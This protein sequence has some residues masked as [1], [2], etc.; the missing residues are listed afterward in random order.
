MTQVREQAAATGSG[1]VRALFLGSAKK[2]AFLPF[3]SPDAE[4]KETVDEVF[5]MVSAWADDTV[6]PAAIDAAAEIPEEVIEGLGELGLLGLIVPEEFGGAGM[7]QYA[8]AR[9]MEAV[10]H[11]CASTVT[12]IGG[13]MGLAM[14]PVLLFGTDEQKQRWLPR[15][16]AAEVLGSFALTEAGAGSDAGNQMTHAVEQPDGSFKVSGTKVMITNAGFAGVFAVFA[17]LADPDAPDAPMKDQ[18]ISCFYVDAHA[19]GV[20]VAP[21]ENKM[22]LKGSST[23]EV[24]FDEVSVPAGDLIGPRG[25]GFKVALNTLNTGRHGLA[26][27]CIGQAKLA[28][29]LAFAQA[30]ERV[31]FGQSIAKFGL[32]QEML[33]GMQADIYAMEAGT[34]L[35]AGLIDRGEE[36]YLLESAACKIFATERLWTLAND[37]LQVAGGIGF[38]KEYPFERIVRD[39]RINLI[40]EGTN[41]ILRTLVAGQGLRPFLKDAA[42]ELDPSELASAADFAPGLA[43]SA[44]HALE[45]ARDLGERTRTRAAAGLRDLLRDQPAMAR[46][47]E[48]A[49]ALY[50]AFAVLSRATAELA[51]GVPDEAALLDVANLA[52]RRRLAGA[53]QALARFDDP[54][55]TLEHR[56]VERAC[57]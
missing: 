12:V 30:K 26:A 49:T 14:K 23:C 53:A 17:R 35:A 54:D 9:L 1:L 37:A 31:Q 55:T 18:P 34:H 44:E 19:E 3:P 16:A 29:E 5:E 52:T 57:S 22:G 39:A 28:S 20:T 56:I 46:L 4:T 50:T 51:A 6:D 45:L 38:M 32:I 24:A 10:A 47:S 13:H 36:D 21:E 15:F 2:A 40:F 7:G 25:G 42:L 48:A 33:A 41:Q 43:K 11:R 8:Y 27:C